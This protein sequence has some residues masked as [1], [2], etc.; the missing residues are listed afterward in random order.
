MIVSICWVTAVFLSSTTVVF[1][2]LVFVLAESA[3]F[4]RKLERLPAAVRE[5]LLRFADVSRELQR[6]LLVKT[7]MAAL[8]GVAAGGWVALLGIDFAVLCGRPSAIS[9]RTSALS[10]PRRRRC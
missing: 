4:P 8:I 10:W 3:V 7:A 5:A 2:L 9:C 1:L 6:Y